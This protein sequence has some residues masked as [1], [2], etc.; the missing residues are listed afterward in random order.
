M[1]FIIGIGAV[2]LFLIGGAVW[3]ISPSPNQSN[4]VYENPEFFRRGF[5]IIPV[6]IWLSQHE[7]FYHLIFLL[8]IL[9]M[10]LFNKHRLGTLLSRMDAWKWACQCTRSTRGRQST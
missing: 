4:P 9:A 7:L 3:F 5:A 2:A 6:I 8:A 1:L 10:V